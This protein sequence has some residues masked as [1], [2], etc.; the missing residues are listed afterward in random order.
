MALLW[1][2]C[3]AS[4]DGLLYYRFSTYALPNYVP[5]SAESNNKR[6]NMVYLLS[7]MYIAC[8]S[9]LALLML[10]LDWKL[11]VETGIHIVLM[12]LH[13]LSIQQSLLSRLQFFAVPSFLTHAGAW[14]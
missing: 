8:H 2:C 3:C 1:L 12:F 14:L 9:Y 11:G 4:A 5:A 6:T 10:Q 7:Q 13:C